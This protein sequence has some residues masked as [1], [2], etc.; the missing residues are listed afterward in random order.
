MYL[1]EGSDNAVTLFSVNEWGC[2][3]FEG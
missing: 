2:Q 3:I 1:I